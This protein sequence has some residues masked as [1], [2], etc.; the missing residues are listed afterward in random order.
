MQFTS[1]MTA[2]GLMAIAAAAPADVVRR[3]APSATGYMTTQAYP[4]ATGTAY[5]P[6]SFGTASMPIATGIYPTGTAS[7]MPM[8]TGSACPTNGALVCSADGTMF[9]L[10]NWGSV[11]FQPVA[12]GTKCVDGKIDFA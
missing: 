12:A 7:Y 5:Y 3:Q 6:S 11:S 2:F 1:T 8:G 10:C 4:V 9:G